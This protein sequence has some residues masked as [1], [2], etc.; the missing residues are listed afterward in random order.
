MTEQ[1]K[2]LKRIA[3]AIFLVFYTLCAI[4]GVLLAIGM[5]GR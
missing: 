4:I 1:E 2:Q 5:T 3:D